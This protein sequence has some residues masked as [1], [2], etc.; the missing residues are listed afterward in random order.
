MTW[1]MSLKELWKQHSIKAMTVSIIT[2]AAASAMMLW[3]PETLKYTLWYI[4]GREC[5]TVI[6]M[7]LRNVKQ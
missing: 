4:A 5:L 7:I 1:E 6:T 3:Q 2:G